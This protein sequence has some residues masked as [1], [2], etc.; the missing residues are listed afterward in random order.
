MNYGQVFHGYEAELA[1]LGVESESLTYVFLELTGWSKTDLILAQNQ[2][3]SPAHAELLGTI[4]TDLCQ[5][6]PAQHI[7]GRAYFRD[8][9]LTVDERVLIPRPETEELVDLILEENSR[10]GLS[11]LD[12]GTGSGAIALSLAKHGQSWTVTASDLSVDALEV[13]KENA[14]KLSLPV[15]FIQSDVFDQIEGVFDIIVSNPPYIA[16]E[17]KDEVGQNVFDYEPHTA[18]FAEDEGLAVYAKIASQAAAHLAPQG[19]IYL[20]IGYK[21][22]QAVSQLFA[23]AFPEKRVRVLKDA[24][25]KDRMVV[26]N[27][28]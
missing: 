13:A 21:Q 17:D 2:P 24:F 5:H 11:V 1:S 28:G 8:L 12:I 23:S 26:V 19:K 22:G 3:V 4:M 25:G 20:E 27:H 9:T 18:L 14:Q 7:T 15:Q 16:Y 10:A 6:R